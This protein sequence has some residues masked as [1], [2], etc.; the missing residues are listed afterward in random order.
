MRRYLR[1]FDWASFFLVLAICTIGLAFVFSATYQPDRPLSIFFKKQLFGIL[2]GI[3]IYFVA[4]LINHNTFCKLGH[5]T[6]YLVIALLVFTKLKGSI[7][8]GAQRWINLF[9]F[10][11]QPSE[12]AKLFFSP[13]ITYHFHTYGQTIIQRF[14]IFIY[15]LTI[16]A[17]TSFL[18]LRQ[19]DLGTALVFFFGGLILLWFSGIK[20]RFFVILFLLFATSAPIL[21][22]TLKPY[23]KQ[24]I[25]VFLGYGDTQK[26]R[27]QIEQATIA[28]GSGGLTGKG[29]LNGTQNKLMF[30]PEGRTD[31]I[32]A[33]LCEEIGFLGA[34][35]VLLLYLALFLTIISKIKRFESSLDQLLALGLIVY[36]FLAVAINIG[37][38]VE[39]LPVV[40]VPLPFMS[41]GVS[42]LWICFASF[43]M[44][45][46][47]VIRQSYIGPK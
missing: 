35:L 10:K 12:L 4:S 39:L 44:I 2:S 22:K 5:N 34:M 19:P 47:I 30:L 32:F 8:M 20:R 45:Q 36:T 23:Q 25:A 9:F 15:P 43:G 6:N 14:K 21:W 24:R 42:H 7:G 28:V 33:V 3:V 27:Y 41:Y 11:F 1:Y 13:F 40:G 29:F 38:V 16:L 17:I 18:I 26:E 31:F 37:M 46:S